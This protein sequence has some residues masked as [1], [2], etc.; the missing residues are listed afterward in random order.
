MRIVVSGTH[1]SGKSTLISDF[2]ALHPEFRVFGDPFDD[3]DIDDPT[4]ERSFAL[5]LQAT[6]TR[7]RE[8]SGEAS[9]I[10][11]RGPLDFL[12]YLTALERLGRSDG[13][14]L[15]RAT[16]LVT[17]SMSTIDLLAVLP[18]EEHRTIHVP[19]DEDPALRLTMD[20]ALGEL[21]DELERDGVL[22]RVVTITGDPEARLRL[23][24]E[25]CTA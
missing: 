1:A 10:G 6:A 2:H 23:L 25:A 15:P 13:T 21:L 14:L 20:E 17:A 8:W 7:Q 5:Q 22:P 12:A 9:V 11:E 24:A 4:G 19:E 18:L 3:L 16:E